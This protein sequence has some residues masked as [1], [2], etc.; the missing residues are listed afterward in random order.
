M[1]VHSWAGRV[2]DAHAHIIDLVR[3]PLHMRIPSILHRLL[4][5]RDLPSVHHAVS[6]PFTSY[7]PQQPAHS[8]IRFVHSSCIHMCS[9]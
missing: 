4:K 3:G 5:N 8:Q 9:S 7:S 6:L 2:G 1:H